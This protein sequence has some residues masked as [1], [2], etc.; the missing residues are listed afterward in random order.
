MEYLNN[1]QK[2]KNKGKEQLLKLKKE[3]RELKDRQIKI[4][5]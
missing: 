3:F 2:N 5:K 1:I 4:R